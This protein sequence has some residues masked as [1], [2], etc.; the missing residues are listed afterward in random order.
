MTRNVLIIEDNRSIGELVGMHMT[1]LGMHPM[2]YEL[3]DSGLER[4]L[5]GGIDLVI[6]DLMLP[7]MDGL[8]LC[9]EIRARPG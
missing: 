9:R 1:D 5:Q 6:L 7:G 2:L 3:G 8:S 4:F